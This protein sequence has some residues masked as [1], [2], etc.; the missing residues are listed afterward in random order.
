MNSATGSPEIGQWYERADS[1][2]LFQV[3][4]LDEG[5][6]TVEIQS[7]DGDVGEIEARIWSGLPLERVQLPEDGLGPAEEMEAQD[8]AFSQAETLLANPRA[9]EQLAE[10]GSGN[11]I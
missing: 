3:T 5:A 9:L 6:G 8:L 1:G 4:G 2:T 7:F 10:L 11:F